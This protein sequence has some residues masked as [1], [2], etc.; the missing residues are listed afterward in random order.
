VSGVTLAAVR[1]PIPTP[2]APLPKNVA[3]QGSGFS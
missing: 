2:P 1:A 3:T